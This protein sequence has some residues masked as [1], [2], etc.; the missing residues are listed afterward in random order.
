MTTIKTFTACVLSISILVF[1]CTSNTKEEAAA[2]V[3]GVEDTFTLTDGAAKN[4]ALRTDTLQQVT[5]TKTLQVAGKVDVPPQNLVSIS[6]P[7]GGYLNSISLLPGQPIKKGQIIAVLQDQ[8]YIQLQQDY[9]TI[10][11]Q[12]P[13]LE[14]EFKR[15]QAMVQ[16][17]ATSTK[18]VQVAESQYRSSY[19]QLQGLAEKLRMIGINPA[20]LQPN[21][22]S[23]LVYLHSPINGYVTKVNANI[24]K[25]VA[26]TDILV[27]L[28]DPTD[29]HL[30]L[31]VFEK[32]VNQI[33]IGQH[34]TAFT[35][36]DTSKT[37]ECDIILIG[38]TVEADRSTEI[39][40]HF[41]QYDA[42][43]IPGTF[44]QAHININTAK[45]WVLPKEAVVQFEENNWVFIALGKNQY[46]MIPVTLENGINHPKWIA[47]QNPE[48]LMGKSIV[49][50]GAYTLLMAHKNKAEEE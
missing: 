35:N 16:S 11:A 28:I 2:E 36:N 15:Q 37:Y 24:G 50:T 38:K 14:Q 31:Q 9:L 48:V 17:N 40:C 7:L 3:E 47:I 22:I 42:T 25:Y 27:E 34:V 32:D 5:L 45:Q 10:Q 23:K 20:S 30:A 21:K 39:H 33:R 4:I 6:V 49:S 18:N 12:L 8:Q 46:K 44:M 43:L 1:S 29:I 19:I 13:A 26:P 41:D